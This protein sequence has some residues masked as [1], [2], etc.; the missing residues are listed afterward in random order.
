MALSSKLFKLKEWFSI[1]ETAKRL[2]SS[3]GEEVT[4]VDIYRLALDRHLT[5]SLNIIENRHNLIVQPVE[6]RQCSIKDLFVELGDGYEA[7]LHTNANLDL[8]TDHIIPTGEI[9]NIDVGFVDFPMIGSEILEVERLYNK[10][11]NIETEERYSSHGILIK[12][13]NG[14]L[15]RLM[16]RLYDK[17]SLVFAKYNSPDYFGSM[18]KASDY[19]HSYII[20]EDIEIVV[21]RKN[22]EKFELAL[23][24][25][26]NEDE[27]NFEQ[28]KQL[29]ALILKAL[30]EKASKQWSQDDLSTYIS[31]EL[32]VHG[33]GKTKINKF[34]SQCN[35]LIKSN[36]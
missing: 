18:S 25:N 31:E 9:V 4:P 16:Q 2:T 19:F 15:Y 30:K 13:E 14:K 34:F 28:S 21:R 26:N 23:L 3:L 6:L 1:D 32:T 11:R 20:P 10:S 22:I 35:K 29:I 17:E 7:L 27:I 36:K 33:L 8:V 12:S 24:E 5:L